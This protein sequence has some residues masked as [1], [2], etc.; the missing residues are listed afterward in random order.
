MSDLKKWDEKIAALLDKMSLDE[1]IGQLNQ[2]MY[3]GRNFDEVM[4]EVQA[5]KAGSLILAGSAHAGNDSQA[6]LGSIERINEIQKAAIES[7]GIPL[8]YG[9][10]VI[11]GHSVVYPV[12]LAMAASFDSE[13]IQH[14]YEAISEEA[15]ND[16]IHWT[17]APMIDI[18]R[19]PRWGR[20]VEGA[21]EDPYLASRMAEA[22]VKGFQGDDHQRRESIAACTKHYVGYGASEGGRDYNPTEIGELT[23]RNFYL[24][25][26]EA[27]VKSG[28]AT[29]MSAFNSISGQPMSS[30]EYL[31]DDVLKKEFGFDGF[32]ISD[33]D[34]V[35][36][37][38][39]FGTARDRKECTEQCLNAGIDMDMADHCYINH[40][41][42][43]IE[44]GKVS[45]ETLDEAV[46]RVLRIKMEYGLFEH[47]YAE[48]KAFDLNQHLNLAVK[49]AEESMVLLKNK[50]NILP[51]KKTQ[52]IAAIGPMMDLRRD[53]LGTWSLDFDISYVQTIRE[54]LKQCSDVDITYSETM[55][56]DTMVMAG[57][58]KDVTVVFLGES[59]AVT[60]EA[61]SLASADIPKDQVELVKKLHATGQKVVAVLC[62]GRTV[63]VGEIEPYCD[64]MLYAW[65]SGTGMAQA[66]VNVL[67]GSKVPSGCLPMTILRST[68]Q[69][70]LYYNMPRAGRD[71]DAY[72]NPD[73]YSC[74]EDI[75]ASPMYPFGYG[76]SYTTFTYSNPV[77]ETCI[78]FDELMNGK[79][80]IVS[81]EVTNTG[82]YDA[83]DIVQCYVKDV[84]ASIARPVREL[85]G[86]HKVW[87]RQGETEKIFFELGLD[88]LGFYNRRNQFTAER[89]LFEVYVGKSAYAQNRVDFELK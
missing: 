12:P 50:D 27:A 62:F 40:L 79:K 25:P 38:E 8:I 87:L 20:S 37:L 14:C 84:H 10:D 75:E 73:E 77:L 60:G 70:P 63:A 18:S 13:L 58:K 11:H 1:K 7:C 71:A 5:G 28:V 43:L 34:A 35:S 33:W 3:N 21:G 16:A 9:H 44:E 57:R 65:H 41:K 89:G 56:Q 42:A 68:T 83:Y 2:I 39:V 36:M 74:Y 48:F 29:V 52:K 64:A 6:V 81:T 66:I 82:N 30:N 67:F 46:R 69:I 86:F 61:R 32:V 26:F 31:L 59:V 47:P 51:L 15:A 80:I 19:D 49:S 53:L 78:S 88:E 17:F 76:L 54:A 55:L 22:V 4:E 72:Y 23:L 24:R 85:K 45:M